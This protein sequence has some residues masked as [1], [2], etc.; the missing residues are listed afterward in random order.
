MPRER[1]R[2]PPNRYYDWFTYLLGG[3]VLAAIAF[4]FVVW[5]L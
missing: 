3:L 4:A 1:R 2:R 5:V